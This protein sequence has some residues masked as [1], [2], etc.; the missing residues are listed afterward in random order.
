MAIGDTVQAGLMRAVDSSAIERAGQAQA[1]IRDTDHR[2]FGD[3]LY[4][5][6][7]RL[8]TRINPDAG[9]NIGMQKLAII[10]YK[11]RPSGSIL[12]P[13]FPRICEPSWL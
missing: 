11:S 10:G 5:S 1:M 13:E 2:A 9:V 12:M 8:L 6:G 3:A 4:D 7:K